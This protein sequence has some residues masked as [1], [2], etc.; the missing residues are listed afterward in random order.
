MSQP[1]TWV[2]AGDRC[3]DLKDQPDS[4]IAL[5]DEVEV[6]VVKLVPAPTG[7][8]WMWSMLLTHPG[9]AFRQPTNGRCETRGQAAR[10]LGACYSA[11]RAFSGLDDG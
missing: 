2:R 9:P 5:D 10:D 7:A 11:F 1:L 4:F 3:P 8:E 6:G